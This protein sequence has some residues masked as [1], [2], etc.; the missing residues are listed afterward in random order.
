MDD[1]EMRVGKSCSTGNGLKNDLGM[2]TGV[3]DAFKCC[4]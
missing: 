3:T 2:S 1:G 4:N